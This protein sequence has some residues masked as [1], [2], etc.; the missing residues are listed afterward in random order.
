MMGPPAIA[1]RSVRTPTLM[2][3]VP[4]SDRFVPGNS[5]A[6]APSPSQPA[7]GITVA[8]IS[9]RVNRTSHGSADQKNVVAT[10]PTSDGRRNQQRNRPCDQRAPKPTKLRTTYPVLIANPARVTRNAIDTESPVTMHAPVV[11]PRSTA[12]IPP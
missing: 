12:V 6:M 3:R 8:G 7:A 9:A 2:R 1:A 11:N 5:R 10:A 4:P